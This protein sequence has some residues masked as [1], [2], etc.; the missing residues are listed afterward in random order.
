[1]SIVSFPPAI[2]AVKVPVILFL[3]VTNVNLLFNFLS[4]L[5]RIIFEELGWHH[6]TLEISNAANDPWASAAVAE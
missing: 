4:H 1:M 5:Q 6:L 3:V 2:K